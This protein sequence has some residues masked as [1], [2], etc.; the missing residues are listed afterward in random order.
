MFLI[1][2]AFLAAV[3]VMLMPAD[4]Q[5][6]VRIASTAT[7]AV[8]NAATFCDRNAGTCA[9]AGEFWGGFV[10]KAQFTAQ[11][12]SNLVHDYMSQTSD[13]RTVAG[14]PQAPAQSIPA[15]GTL[16]PADLTPPWRGGVQRTRT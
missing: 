9:A 13:R 15:R 4:E 14:T 5:R 8:G 10:K 1:R 12:A 7:A 11:L 16:S 3:A 2:L 6:Q